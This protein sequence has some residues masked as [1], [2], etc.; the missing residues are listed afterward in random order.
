MTPHQMVA[1]VLD[2]L[3]DLLARQLEDR[4]SG[5]P[6]EMVRERLERLVHNLENEPPTISK[7]QALHELSFLAEHSQRE[8]LLDFN[9]GVRHAMQVTMTSAW[10]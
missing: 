9:R 7:M 2:P 4:P 5:D 8:D 6:L 1:E 10:A 3:R